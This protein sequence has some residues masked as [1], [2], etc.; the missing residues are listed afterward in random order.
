[1]VREVRHDPEGHL[2]LLGEGRV[3]RVA[4]G[5][6]DFGELVRGGL[7]EAI[8][9]G[10]GQGDR[11]TANAE[12]SRRFGGGKPDIEPLAPAPVHGIFHRK[13]A[14]A[15]DVNSVTESEGRLLL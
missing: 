2:P 9:R 6:A 14:Y 8:D 11:H 5:S 1:M 4:R 15:A 3:V 13:I 12:I 10:K 7:V